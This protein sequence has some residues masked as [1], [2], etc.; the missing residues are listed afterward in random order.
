MNCPAASIRR[1]AAAVTPGKSADSAAAASPMV[2][3]RRLTRPKDDEAAV[4]ARAPLPARPSAAPRAVRVPAPLPFVDPRVP[5][6]VSPGPRGARWC[7]VPSP[8]PDPVCRGPPTGTDDR[9]R[10]GSGPAV[11]A[12]R[13]PRARVHATRR[14]FTALRSA[15]PADAEA[16]TTSGEEYQPVLAD[17]DLVAV[18]EED[19]LDA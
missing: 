10:T 15:F 8:L 12:C 9:R 17:L 14:R 2:R 18:R 6:M 3:V 4:C 7:S 19:F 11:P 5:A 1:S 16:L 13:V